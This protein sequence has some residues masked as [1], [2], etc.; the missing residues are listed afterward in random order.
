M[1]VGSTSW[2]AHEMQTSSVRGTLPSRAFRTSSFGFVVLRSILSRISINFPN[3]LLV[4]LLLTPPKGVVLV[5][6]LW[7]DERGEI[8]SFFTV[9]QR[10]VDT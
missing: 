3:P 10:C 6:E 5:V 8:H 2:L 7:S 9:L 1:C 4:D